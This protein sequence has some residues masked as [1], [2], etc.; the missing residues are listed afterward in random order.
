MLLLAED[1]D[2][3]SLSAEPAVP[4]D[5]EGAV[6]RARVAKALPQVCHHDIP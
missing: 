6:L 3:F 5:E 1:D 4:S 2:T